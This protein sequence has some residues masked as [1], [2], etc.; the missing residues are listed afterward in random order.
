[1]MNERT[2]TLTPIWRAFLKA[3]AERQV[4]FFFDGQTYAVSEFAEDELRRR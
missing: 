3:A 4:V 1:M 2:I